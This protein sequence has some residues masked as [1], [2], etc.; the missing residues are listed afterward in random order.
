MINITFYEEENRVN[1]ETGECTW[2]F[3]D[4]HKYEIDNKGVVYII[5][6]DGVIRAKFPFV[7]CIIVFED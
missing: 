5:D 7:N 1:I 2:D 3:Y 6:D 4:T